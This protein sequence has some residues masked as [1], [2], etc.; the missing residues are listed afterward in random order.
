MKEPEGP[1]VLADIELGLVLENLVVLG[2]VI[3]SAVTS[4][5]E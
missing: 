5:L 1:I 4:R 3:Q 2:F